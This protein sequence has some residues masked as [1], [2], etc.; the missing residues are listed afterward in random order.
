MKS[1]L[2]R[3]KIS[4]GLLNSEKYKKTMKS[5]Q[6]KIKQM[7]TEYN[8]QKKRKV[9][10]IDLGVVYESVNECA[11]QMFGDRKYKSGIINSI[12]NKKKYH[13]YSFQYL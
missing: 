6:H 10:C 1:K 13:R 2:I 9:I 5:E 8:N 7:N 11:R 12:K 4:E 3:K